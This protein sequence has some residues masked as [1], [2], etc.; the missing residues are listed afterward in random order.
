MDP[1]AEQILVLRIFLGICV[2]SEDLCTATLFGPQIHCD[3]VSCCEGSRL[4]LDL[5]P[6]S[7]PLDYG[8]VQ[9]VKGV[10]SECFAVL[11]Q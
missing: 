3:C 1:D 8:F 9:S 4:T 6:G 10:A 5:A 7:L 11:I 2:G